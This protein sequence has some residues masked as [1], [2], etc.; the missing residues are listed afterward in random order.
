MYQKHEEILTEFPV[1]VNCRQCYNTIYNSLPLSLHKLAEKRKG[2]YRFL[3]DYLSPGFFTA[4][5]T[6]P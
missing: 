5:K 6:V 3:S 2:K 4:R 1:A